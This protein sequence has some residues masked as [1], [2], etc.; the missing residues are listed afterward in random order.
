MLTKAAELT[1]EAAAQLAIFLLAFFLST[2]LTCGG[3]PICDYPRN[4]ASEVGTP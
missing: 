3:K 1:G 2:G 4:E